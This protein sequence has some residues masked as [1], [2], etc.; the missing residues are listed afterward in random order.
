MY[1]CWG[2]CYKLF[3]LDRQIIEFSGL[4]RPVFK[5]EHRVISN[6]HLNDLE[7]DGL[8]HVLTGFKF[9]SLFVMRIPEGLCLQA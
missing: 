9:L 1:D 2:D 5:P 4:F 7:L 6:Q 8:G 3:A